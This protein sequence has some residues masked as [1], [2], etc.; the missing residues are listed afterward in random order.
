[1]HIFWTYCAYG[2]AAQICLT[3]QCFFS[4]DCLYVCEESILPLPTYIPTSIHTAVAALSVMYR[5]DVLIQAINTEG[6]EA[7]MDADGYLS[8]NLGSSLCKTSVH[9][10]HGNLQ[11]N[12]KVI[13]RTFL[14]MSNSSHT[15]C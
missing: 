15:V 11:S 14:Y 7:L 4:S 5:V 6:L 1:M 12:Q 13:Y 8:N 3:N 10:L 9:S 2:H